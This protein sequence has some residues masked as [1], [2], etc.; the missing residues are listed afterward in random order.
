MIPPVIAIALVGE[1]LWPLV[2]DLKPWV[3][4]VVLIGVLQAVG[5]AAV[6]VYRYTL[7]APRRAIA[8]QWSRHA[9]ALPVLN[10]I[11]AHQ[12]FV[13]SMLTMVAG[14]GAYAAVATLGLPDLIE[15]LALLVGMI[16][17][18][19]FQTVLLSG[20]R[21]ARREARALRRA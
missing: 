6:L 3:I 20:R 2:K 9:V 19:W 10:R 16:G 8:A 12:R 15:L 11:Y 14:Y 1:L 7:G 17:Q 13:A 18:I 5:L 4:A 21:E